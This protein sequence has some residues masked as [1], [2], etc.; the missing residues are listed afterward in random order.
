[1]NRF[2][3]LGWDSL[4]LLCYTA[5]MNYRKKEFRDR[6]YKKTHKDSTMA[7]IINSA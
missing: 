7:R 6:L 5:R 2:L 1:M 3:I 4:H